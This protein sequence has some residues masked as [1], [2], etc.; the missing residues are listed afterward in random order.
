MTTW[1]HRERLAAVTAVIEAA[2]PR[3]VVDL[4]CGGGDLLVGLA[5]NAGIARLVGLD[6]SAEAIERLRSRLSRADVRAGHVDLRCASMA[7]PA[8]DLHG[9]DCAALVETIEHLDAP[10]RARMERAVFHVMRP[11]LAVMTTP[12]AEFNR[13]LGVPPN[14]FRHP[15]H[16]FEWT[17][18]Q[19][20]TWARRIAETAGYAVEFRDIA[21]CHPDLGGASQMAVFRTA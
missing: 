19:F 10:Q 20:R 16:R 11:R 12:N 2:A 15:G 3:S 17:R 14:R 18:A 8:H 13:L 1:L 5:G 6:I 7:D 9:I 4:G 21:G